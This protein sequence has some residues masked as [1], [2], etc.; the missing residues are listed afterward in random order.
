M[1]KHINTGEIILLQENNDLFY[2]K[3][4]AGEGGACAIF[5]MQ[6][7]YIRSVA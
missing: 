6:D 4:I 7:R 2:R 1:T 5:L 3:T